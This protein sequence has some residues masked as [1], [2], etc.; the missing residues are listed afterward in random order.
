MTCF[1]GITGALASGKSLVS[2]ILQNM[3]YRVFDADAQVKNLY[4][5]Q[6]IQQQ[7]LGLFA[8]LSRID[9]SYIARIIYQDKAKRLEMN[10]IFHPIIKN[11]LLKYLA[12][13]KRQG[14]VFADIPLLYEANFEQFFHYTICAYAPREICLQRFKAREKRKDLRQDCENLFNLINESQISLEKKISKSSFVAYTHD[15]K[16]NLKSQLTNIINRI[17]VCK[18]SF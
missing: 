4:E 9:K 13:E 6:D 5:K 16:F 15:T 14:I 2:A 17:K 12:R 7:V 3:G 11:E 8:D 18:K 10:K 1:I